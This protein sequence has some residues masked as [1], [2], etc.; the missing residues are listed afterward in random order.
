MVRILVTTCIFLVCAAVPVWLE[1][2]KFAVD[3][4]SL[5]PEGME[6]PRDV[7]ERAIV[8]CGLHVSQVR[9]YHLYVV[10]VVISQVCV[11]FTLQAGLLWNT[12]REFEMAVLSSLQVTTPFSFC[13]SLCVYMHVS[14]CA[15]K[16]SCVQ[17]LFIE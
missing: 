12:Y 13:L 3:K 8:A 2:A 17:K 5:M 16:P 6:F 11:S 14:A 1:Y 10:H 7:F 9:M 4:M 15:N